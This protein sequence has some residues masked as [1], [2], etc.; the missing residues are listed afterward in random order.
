MSIWQVN[1]NGS[2]PFLRL[3]RTAMRTRRRVKAPSN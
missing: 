1:A 2:R 3:M